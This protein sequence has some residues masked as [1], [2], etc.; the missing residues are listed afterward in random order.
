MLKILAICGS[1]R[2]NSTNMGLVR[3]AVQS[4][5]SQQFSQAIQKFWPNVQE[6]LLQPGYSGVR[7][8]LAGIE[9]G[10]RDFCIR[11]HIVTN[12]AAKFI[13]LYGIESPGLTSSLAIAATV[14]AMA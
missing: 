6:V 5:K 11:N 12:S 7:P 8:V 10:F 2:K 3:Y 13:G 4:N 1:L 14:T 9:G